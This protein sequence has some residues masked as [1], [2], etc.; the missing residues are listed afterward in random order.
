MLSSS[1]FVLMPDEEVSLERSGAM[2]NQGIR[3]QSTEWINRTDKQ[4][5]GAWEIRRTK[6]SVLGL[7]NF[8]DEEIVLF[9]E[10][11]VEA[12]EKWYPNNIDVFFLL[13]HFD[14]G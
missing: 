11:F 3:F 10:G 4:N 5:S 8:T 6:Q 1:N 14:V 9:K 2:K 12:I 7:V 13:Q